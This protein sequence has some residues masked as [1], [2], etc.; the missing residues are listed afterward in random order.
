MLFA[1]GARLETCMD[2]FPFRP[3]LKKGGPC[4]TSAG[5]AVRMYASTRRDRQIGADRGPIAVTACHVD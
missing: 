5:A 1:T 3:D 2:I 4:K